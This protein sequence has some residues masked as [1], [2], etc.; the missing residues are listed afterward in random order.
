MKNSFEQRGGANEDR[1]RPV[2]VDKNLLIIL[3]KN[4]SEIVAGQTDKSIAALQLLARLNP[5]EKMKLNGVIQSLTGTKGRSASPSPPLRRP[6]LTP[7]PPL[8][9]SQPNKPP[10]FTFLDSPPRMPQVKC[11]V[12]L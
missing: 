5:V 12:F 7:S 9:G 11:P 2:F 1:D 3:N 4:C 6:D 8:F 10:P